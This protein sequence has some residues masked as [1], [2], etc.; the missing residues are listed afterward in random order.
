MIE[1]KAPQRIYLQWYGDVSAAEIAAKADIDPSSS[2]VTWCADKIHE[3]DIEYVRV[4]L[5]RGVVTS[6]FESKDEFIARMRALIG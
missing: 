3:H 5:L 4:D 6:D 2:D 1:D